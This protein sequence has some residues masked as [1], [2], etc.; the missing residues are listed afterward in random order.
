MI[1]GNILHYKILE[2]LG[3]GGM[4]V[5]YKAEDTK[6]KRHVAIKF[7]PR[8]ISA[9]D[10]ERERFEIEAQ[11]AAALNHPNIATIHAIEEH[12]DEIFIVMEYIEGRELK[13]IISNSK[14]EIKNCLDYASQIGAGL[15]AA[16]EKGVTHR[17]IKSA[18][19]MITDKGQIKIMDF[20]LAKIR[21][22]AQVT[23][24]GTTLGTAA[25][26][27]PE[28]ARGEETDHRSDIWSFGVVLYEMLTGKLPFG[29]D[30]EQAILYS[31]MNEEPDYPDH[32]PASMGSVLKK[33]LTKDVEYRYQTM[34]QLLSEL[35]SDQPTETAPIRKS[36]PTLK[37]K[38][39]RHLMMGGLV[40]LILVISGFALFK[41]RAE[42]ID[43]IAVLPFADLSSNKDQAYFCDGMTEEIVAELTKMNPLKVIARTSV[44]RYK[45]TQK[46]IGEIGAELDVATVLEG[47]IRKEESNLR[48]SASLI[49]VSDESLIWSKQYERKMTGI[50]A[51]QKEVARDLAN[52]MKLKRVTEPDSVIGS[53][54][55]I[56]QKAYE[57]YL[58]GSYNLDSR[59]II[60]HAESDFE[61][62]LEMFNLAIQHD[63][64][65]AL[66]Y[67][68]LSTAYFYKWYLTGAANPR[69]FDLQLQNAE[70]ALKLNPNLAGAHALRG[71]IYSLQ[72]D[73]DKAYQ[74]LSRALD[75]NLNDARTNFFAGLFMTFNGLTRHSMVFYAKSIELDPHFIPTYSLLAEDLIFMNKMDDA[76][77]Y[78]DKATTLETDFFANLRMQT[79]LAI[80]M[81]EAEQAD[82]LISKMAEIRPGL[83]TEVT[84]M[85]YASQ[86]HTDEALAISQGSYIQALLGR[87][88]ETIEAL[89]NEI[90]L[91]WPAYLQLLH[92][93]IF[94]DVRSEPAFQEIIKT[95]TTFYDS[96]IQKYGD[97]G[98]H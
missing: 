48:L 87:K 57:Y 59:Y 52:A 49:K 46:S 1:G 54:F 7:L 64:T 53:N 9:S 60:S 36:R 24:I 41:D 31:I 43:S 44:M 69:L 88:T 63:T 20:G 68:G 29:G 2:K 40:L 4:G 94:A 32:I 95:Q 55:P 77:N 22:G 96:K 74:S 98:K 18:N 67:V 58:K 45:D 13:E 6:L 25:Y 21:G 86:G 78:L 47:S 75:L 39:T 85:F 35:E 30:Y 8:H 11:A 15:Q 62:A 19:I 89:R 61:A 73:F 81:M 23:K 71:H 26:M 66:P 91:G 93:P 79:I 56:N 10:E 97:L 28:Q 50:F 80:L 12:E 65:Y 16:H 83:G 92:N 84:A 72:R 70:R 76:R 17:D 5:V 27:S 14:L 38:T 51:F 42:A 34:T 82:S 3:E 33:A 90:D 37:A